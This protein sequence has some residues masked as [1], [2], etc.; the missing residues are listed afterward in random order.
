MKVYNIVAARVLA[1]NV[2]NAL[3]L[4]LIFATVCSGHIYQFVHHQ[5]VAAVAEEEE[6][7]EEKALQL[8]IDQQQ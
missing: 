7:E 3:L 2:H 6:E 5:N 1:C 8:L 4:D